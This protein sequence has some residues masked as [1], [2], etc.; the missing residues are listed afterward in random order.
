MIQKKELSL[1][2]C[3]IIIIIT[4]AASVKSQ[5]N[6]MPITACNRYGTKPVGSCFEVSISDLNQMIIHTQTNIIGFTFNFKNG[7]SQSYNENS[8][9]MNNFV[10]NL[11]NI[12]M[13]GV[14]IYVGDGIES[15]KLK[16]YDSM[17]QNFSST[18]KIGNSQK[19]CFSYINSSFFKSQSL[20][21]DLISG[22]VDNKKLNYFPFLEFTYSFSQC[23]IQ[24]FY[25]KIS[26][27][28]SSSTSIKSS[29]TFNPIVSNFIMSSTKLLSLL[30]SSSST[31]L[32]TEITSSIST[33]STSTTT[34]SISTSS[35]ST[36]TLSISTS[37]TST[38]TSSSTTSSTTKITSIHLIA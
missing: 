38:I 36:T 14:D 34:L 29:S 28:I 24:V 37:S 7:S 13:T 11:N 12:Y 21:I 6:C 27:T 5:S 2:Q 26:S 10:I 18:K 9:I 30:T 16:M 20:V 8:G 25:P 3:L 22:C 31:I 33:S 17:T 35:T 1:I 23:P 4:F 19:G 32:T 15:L